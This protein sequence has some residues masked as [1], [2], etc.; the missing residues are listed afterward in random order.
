MGAR[1]FTQP[2][3]PEMVGYPIV[4]SWSVDLGGLRLAS[5]ERLA[6]TRRSVCAMG[7]RT[8]FFRDRHEGRRGRIQLHA[9]RC[10][11]GPL[12]HDA[13][14]VAVAQS[15]VQ[16]CVTRSLWE[17]RT[18]SSR[19][20]AACIRER[21][22]S[23]RS[24]RRLHQPRT[25]LRQKMDGPEGPAHEFGLKLLPAGRIRIG[26]NDVAGVLALRDFS[27]CTVCVHAQ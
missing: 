10:P 22:A 9:S 14:S 27:S 15:G 20:I 24:K 26:L 21:S 18:R 17:A 3:A 6:K 4:A 7:W 19:R 1:S 2:L 13:A 23:L 11:M 5:N 25:E 8:C 16:Q 12:R